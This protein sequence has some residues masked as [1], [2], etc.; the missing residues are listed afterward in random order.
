MLNE[1]KMKQWEIKIASGI[2]MRTNHTNLE[3]IIVR[4]QI[5]MFPDS[6]TILINFV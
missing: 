2:V 4:F 3:K 5:Y 6:Q 1:A